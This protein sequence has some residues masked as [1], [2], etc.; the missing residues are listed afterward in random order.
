M[1]NKIEEI[2]QKLKLKKGD[3]GVKILIVI[4]LIGILLI[5]LSEAVP[6][7]KQSVKSSNNDLAS[8]SDYAHA[9][10]DETAE[11]ISSIEGAGVCKVMLTLKNTNESIYAENNEEDVREGSFSKKSEY[12]LYDAS[13]GDSP[14]L[15]Q[16]KFPQVQGVVVVC[17][18]GDNTVVRENIIKCISALYDIPSTRINVS[19][20]K[21]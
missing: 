11:I 5:A 6:S 15:I 20:L 14:L 10:E 13:S 16:Q 7:Q 18:G 3:K 19:K 2:M 21:V 12:V 1:E 17:S 8:Y 9:L 4:G